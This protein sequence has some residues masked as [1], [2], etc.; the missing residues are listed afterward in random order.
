MWVLTGLG[1]L[2]LIT[3]AGPFAYIHF[4]EGKAP[5]PLTVAS[6][7][8]GDDA[9]QGSAAAP[10]DGTWKVA[11][12]S[13]A[14]YRV[15]E[16]LFGQDNTAAGRTSSVT[17]QVT[18]TGTQVAAASLT[19]DL[20]SVRSDQSRRDIQFQGRIMDT[21]EFPTAT[22][23]LT[24]PLDLGIVPADGTTITAK[25]TGNLTLRATTRSVTFTVTAKRSGTSIQVSGQIP[26]TFSDFNIPNPSFGPVTTQDNGIL[27]FLVVLSHG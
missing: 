2:L 24:S 20:T 6:T 25:V 9:S 16:T 21:A 1:V 14:G 10:L 18:V 8:S 12:G 15:K 27:E 26:V 17:G 11:S 22:F 19:A 13:Q 4:I 5:A 3:V 23:A 7:K